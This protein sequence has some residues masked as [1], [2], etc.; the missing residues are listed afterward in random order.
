M[1]KAYTLSITMTFFS[2]CDVTFILP[3]LLCVWISFTLAFII[4]MT[5][6]IIKYRY[7]PFTI[8]KQG[9]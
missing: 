1:T 7:L 5:G 4:M 9:Q 6:F 3:I 8:G 2:I